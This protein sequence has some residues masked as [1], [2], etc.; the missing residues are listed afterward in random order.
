[1]EVIMG[2]NPL[3]NQRAEGSGP[4]SVSWIPFGAGY[5]RGEQ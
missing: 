1:M 2:K 3:H 5:D 4:K